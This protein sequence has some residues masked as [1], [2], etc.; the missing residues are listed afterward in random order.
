MTPPWITLFIP[1]YNLSS[2]P[3]F[4][5][6]FIRPAKEGGEARNISNALIL[7]AVN[8][9]AK[10]QIVT[11]SMMAIQPVIANQ[12]TRKSICPHKCV[13]INETKLLLAFSPSKS[14][15]RIV[16]PTLSHSKMPFCFKWI[17]I[18]EN[19]SSRSTI[20]WE[21]VEC[22]KIE[23]YQVN[24]SNNY[25]AHTTQLSVFANQ[26]T[27]RVCRHDQYFVKYKIRIFTTTYLEYCL[28]HSWIRRILQS[29]PS[30]TKSF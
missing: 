25:A 16:I 14:F 13:H 23:F 22:G 30:T 5:F 10:N 19:C 26:T 28:A 6:H 27:Q 11:L 7:A 4:H 1:S 9:A 24:Y 12:L 15:R 21:H 29:A 8:H 3:Y 20:R 17:T 18:A 2:S